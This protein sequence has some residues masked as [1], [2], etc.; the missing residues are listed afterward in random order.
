MHRRNIAK[1]K[2]IIETSQNDIFPQILLL[3]FYEI[4]IARFSLFNRD[5]YSL[6]NRLFGSGMLGE[7]AV[8]VSQEKVRGSIVFQVEF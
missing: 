4:F 3:M 8:V 6:D 1:Q 7:C 2:S 5:F